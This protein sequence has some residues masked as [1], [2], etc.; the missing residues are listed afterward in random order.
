MPTTSR[1]GA[2]PTR[3][4]EVGPS[5]ARWAAG[6]TRAHGLGDRVAAPQMFLSPD[7]RRLY[8]YGG[9]TSRGPQTDL[10]VSSADAYEAFARGEE[11]EPRFRLCPSS[12]APAHPG[13][14]QSL[15]PLW[16]P[17]GGAAPSQAHVASL[18]PAGFLRAGDRA[19]LILA[20]GG[21]L[22]GY[23]H[24]H[25][26]LGRRC[27]GGSRR[28]RGPAR[29]LGATR[30]LRDADAALRAHGDLRARA[31]LCGG[32]VVPGGGRG[33]LRRSPRKRERTG[34]TLQLLCVKTWTWFSCR[35]P[36][37]SGILPS[38]PTHGHSA[39]LVERG[40]GT[41]VVFVGGGTGSILDDPARCQEHSVAQ[42]L[43]ELALF[44]RDRVGA[45]FLP[46][47]Q[48]AHESYVPGRHHTACRVS[49]NR[50]VLYGGGDNPDPAVC[51]LDL[52]AVVDA[53]VAAERHR[54]RRALRRRRGSA[55]GLAVGQSLDWLL[56]SRA[57]VSP[58][59]T[60]AL[61][62]LGGGETQP[63]PRKFHAACSLYPWR[64][65]LVIFGGW[66]VDRHF[67][68]MWVLAHG[69]DLASYGSPDGYGSDDDDEVEIVLQVG[70]RR[71]RVLIER[72]TLE[73]LLENG[74]FTELRNGTFAMQP[75][76]AV[77]M[78]PGGS[79]NGREATIGDDDDDDEE[80]EDSY[81][82]DAR[83]WAFGTTNE[84]VGAVPRTR[85]RPANPPRLETSSS[86]TRRP[87][88]TAVRPEVDLDDLVQRRLLDEVRLVRL[89][90]RL[91]DARNVEGVEGAL[92]EHLVRHLVRRVQAARHRAADAARG[93]RQP[94]TGVL[95][96]VRPLERHAPQLHQI[97]T[98][99]PTGPGA[100]ARGAASSRCITKV[101]ACPASP[102]A[103][104]HCCPASR[105]RCG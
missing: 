27:A 15:T 55:R 18:A 44:G 84:R 76:P 94:D 73:A 51:V 101:A 38:P 30:G 80:D 99:A 54:R 31:L 42:V 20:F 3:A 41:Y 61:R 43:D 25:N 78:P 77:M 105:S 58:P 82:D 64:P 36:R 37:G 9:W 104:S 40:G 91:D 23:R 74:R 79:G 67:D 46:T 50:V 19:H 45:R 90:G 75:P 102:A 60:V 39:A 17:G 47:V 10:A 65:L 81:E 87:S 98:A 53:A 48:L 34:P 5:A 22:G 63:T 100:C 2:P 89:H 14:A 96:V 103:R 56:V 86:P 62:D 83:V 24:E 26:R 13:G 68:D 66:Q 88:R 16:L 52:A 71:E 93:V 8:N 49:Q 33:L 35:S 70:G 6:P 92:A 57:S 32:A 11:A 4:V 29:A 12:G 59:A 69:G 72:S 85:T 7:G 95:V 21:G 28:R 97:E 1:A